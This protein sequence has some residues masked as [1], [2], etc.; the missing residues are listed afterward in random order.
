[1][2]LQNQL[3]PSVSLDHADRTLIATYLEILSSASVALATRV[4]RTPDVIVSQSAHAI[5]TPAAPTPSA[6]SRLK[7]CPCAAAKMATKEI[8]W[9]PRAADQNVL[10]MM[11]ALTIRLALVLSVKT[12]ALDHVEL[13][14]L[15]VWRNIIQFAPVIMDLLEIQ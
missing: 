15:V 1:M 4:T 14:H 10:S 3:S 5:Q 9:V 7:V 12:R 13:K 11:S 6:R 2:L 8:L